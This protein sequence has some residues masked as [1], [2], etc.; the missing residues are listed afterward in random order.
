MLPGLPSVSPRAFPGELTL[1]LGEVSLSFLPHC[2]REGWRRRSE[3][4]RDLNALKKNTCGFLYN[5]GWGNAF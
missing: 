4:S 2:R 1:Q 5:S 3:V